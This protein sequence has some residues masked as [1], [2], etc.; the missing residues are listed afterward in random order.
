MYE[1]R[2]PCSVVLEGGVT[3]AVIYASLLARLSRHYAYRQLGG[4]SSGA[5]AATAAAAAEFARAS[6]PTTAATTGPAPVA[7]A[8]DPFAELGKFPR[9]LAKTDPLGRTALYNLFQPSTEARASFLVAMAA[10]EKERDEGWW[11]ACRR[12]VLALMMHFWPAALLLITS[13]VG[14]AV[15]ATDHVHFQLG[16]RFTPSDML[17]ASAACLWAAGGWLSVIVL[18]AVGAL[19]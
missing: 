10:L 18:A 9:Q 16:C 17:S 5:I 8:V 4:A 7:A 6:S 12:V 13:L 14:L 19:T 1:Q 11:A 15:L 3:S 2:S